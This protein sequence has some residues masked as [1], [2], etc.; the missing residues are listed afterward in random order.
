MRR[1]YSL[2]TSEEVDRLCYGARVLI[3][4]GWSC[5]NN[6]EQWQKAGSNVRYYTCSGGGIVRPTESLAPPVFSISLY[7]SP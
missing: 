4:T 7:R 3:R 5:S 1:P 2:Y 6:S